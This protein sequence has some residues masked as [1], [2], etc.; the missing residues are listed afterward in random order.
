LYGQDTF[1]ELIGLGLQNICRVLR[2]AL[3]ATT[4]VPL[5]L[6][7]STVITVKPKGKAPHE[8]VLSKDR[9]V[10]AGPYPDH[11][12]R[13]LA[14]EKAARLRGDLIRPRENGTPAS[15]TTPRIVVRHKPIDGAPL[16][17]KKTEENPKAILPE[18]G[19]G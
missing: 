13:V 15:N 7:E 3:S 8:R 16:A 11:R 6:R 9:I 2:E 4:I 5:S 17:R 19:K 14:A 10:E 12:I 18:G 1:Y